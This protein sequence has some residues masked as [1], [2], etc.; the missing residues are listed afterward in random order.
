[1]PGRTALLR[2]GPSLGRWAAHPPPPPPGGR[3]GPFLKCYLCA[4]VSEPPCPGQPW[5]GCLVTQGP[6]AD[7]SARSLVCPAGLA[8][9]GGD[10]VA[11]LQGPAIVLMKTRIRGTRPP[12]LCCL[13]WY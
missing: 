5:L 1:M 9:Q 10:F 11:V 3:R 4:S 6:S 12:K 13:T 2:V 8:S 7:L